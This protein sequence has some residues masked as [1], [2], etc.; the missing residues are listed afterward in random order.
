MA[1]VL[2]EKMLGIGISNAAVYEPA[3]AFMALTL[4]TVL[5][6]PLVAPAVLCAESEMR[7]GSKFSCKHLEAPSSFYSLSHA[8]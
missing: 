5:L 4:C 3:S 8:D 2:E 6:G 7:L 1:A